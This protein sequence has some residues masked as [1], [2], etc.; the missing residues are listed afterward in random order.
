VQF[1]SIKTIPIAVK[2]VTE[3][4]SDIKMLY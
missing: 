3:S 4:F 1:R 2:R